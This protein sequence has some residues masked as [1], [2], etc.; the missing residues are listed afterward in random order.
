MSYTQ[1]KSF[2]SFS[3]AD[4][5]WGVDVVGGTRYAVPN[6]PSG[7]KFISVDR[8]LTNGEDRPCGNSRPDRV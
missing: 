7:A 2:N 8:L 6:L 4:V 5:K 3:F 1:I